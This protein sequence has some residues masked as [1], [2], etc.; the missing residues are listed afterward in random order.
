MSHDVTVFTP[1]PFVVGQK[2]RI[3]G[4]RRG[5]DWQVIAISDNTV[6]LR[7]PVSLREFEWPIFCYQVREEHD[8]AWPRRD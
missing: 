6:T 7:C 1:Y 4:S 2:I 3:D 5:G 8:V